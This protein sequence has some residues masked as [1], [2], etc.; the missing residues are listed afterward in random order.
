[1]LLKTLHDC[2]PGVWQTPR[3][4]AKTEIM[5]PKNVHKNF[6][7]YSKDSKMRFRKQRA[8]PHWKYLWLKHVFLCFDPEAP[9]QIVQK[10]IQKK[11]R[12]QLMAKDGNRLIWYEYER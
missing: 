8:A 1:M 3:Q 11:S 2:Q 10:K 7:K 6:Q 9:P 5:T 12:N 4:L